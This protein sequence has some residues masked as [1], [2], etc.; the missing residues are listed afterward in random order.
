MDQEIINWLLDS[1]EPWTRY[2]TLIDLQG[3]SDVDLKLV[4][5]KNELIQHPQVHALIEKAATWPGY[6]LKRHNDA[7]HPIYTFST[8]ADYGLKLGDHPDLDAAIEAVLAHQSP[9]GMFE[10]LVHVP[11]AFGGSGEDTLSWMACDSPTLLF[12]LLSF[13]LGDDHR[14]QRAVEALVDLV[15]ENGWRCAA[16]QKFGK[17]K[18]PGRKDDFCPIANVYAL[19]ALSLM[20]RVA[21]QSDKG[22]DELLLYLAIR[23][24]ID[25][26]L[27][28]WEHQSERKIFM[29]GIGTDFRKLK[30][31]Y[32][33]Y[34]ILHVTEVLSRFP[35][36]H[37][38]PR[39]Q[40]MVA[41]LTQQADET[42]R[43][44]AGSMYMAWKGWSFADKKTPSPWLTF[45][46]LR[47]LNRLQTVEA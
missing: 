24:G 20:G 40:E 1:D 46:V 29:F 2:R 32:V 36:V 19:K 42:G 39:F 27:Y 13:G 22:Q 34:D 16:S 44:R 45:L 31:P 38:D 41:T 15:R 5:A 43:Y 6:A 3:C 30:Y 23:R 47:I 26:L 8:L 11:E 35:F 21:L 28:H 14:V 33:W 9:R 25:A 7:A 17:F 10:T 18:G 12:T 4:A 37:A